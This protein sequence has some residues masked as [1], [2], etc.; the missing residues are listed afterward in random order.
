MGAPEREVP[1]A[2]G[3]VCRERQGCPRG[4]WRGRGLIQSQLRGA[5]EQVSSGDG[6]VRRAWGRS[7]RS[8]WRRSSALT[9][10]GLS[11]VGLV[12]P[13]RPGQGVRRR[14]QQGQGAGGGG[15][16]AGRVKTWAAGR[17]CGWAGRRVDRAAR[18]QAEGG[19]AAVRDRSPRRARARAAASASG[20]RFQVRGAGEGRRWSPRLP[21]GSG[22]RGPQGAPPPLSPTRADAPRRGRGRRAACSAGRQAGFG[23]VPS[24]H[25]DL[26][27]RGPDARPCH[28]SPGSS[29][30]EARLRAPFLSSFPSFPADRVTAPPPAPSSPRELA[31]GPPTGKVPGGEG[32]SHARRLTGRLRTQA[33]RPAS[34]LPPGPGGAPCAPASICPR[35]ELCLEDERPLAGLKPRSPGRV[36]PALAGGARP[37]GLTSRRTRRASPWP[38]GPPAA[39]RGRRPAGLRALR[40][41][42]RGP[43]GAQGCIVQLCLAKPERPVRFLREHFEAGQGQCPVR[44]V[45]AGRRVGAG[46]PAALPPQCAQ[47]GQA[48]PSA[49]PS[50]PGRPTPP[51]GP[52]PAQALSAPPHPGSLGSFGKWWL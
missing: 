47:L 12:Q 9:C 14:G 41:E 49:A 5:G 24:C 29:S 40:A 22:K 20:A 44:L 7:W 8:P 51:T 15:A 38:P 36:G 43:A 17:G 4:G 31:G 18:R 46:A 26:A 11:N 28:C 35:G 37:S 42:A 2:P 33:S 16:V 45:P 50:R 3:R 10:V 52:R 1:K 27:E 48:P 32:W 19:A 6:G 34:L 25:C 23:R 13:A 30:L 21:G 39:G